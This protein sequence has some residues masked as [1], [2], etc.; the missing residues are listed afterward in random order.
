MPNANALK[1]TIENTIV[2]M[3]NASKVE[4]IR[5]MAKSNDFFLLL[6]TLKITIMPEFAA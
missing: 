2:P 5:M 4:A 1:P 3:N 6:C